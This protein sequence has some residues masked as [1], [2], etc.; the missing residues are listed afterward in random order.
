MKC[1]NVLIHIYELV[2]IE[3][4]IKIVSHLDAVNI[5]TVIRQILDGVNLITVVHDFAD[6]FIQSTK[7]KLI[8]S[9][10]AT[11]KCLPQVDLWR[12]LLVSSWSITP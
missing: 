2:Y 4:I 9:K 7:H 10:T 3:K 6:V 1:N 8:N 11:A 5:I 12:T